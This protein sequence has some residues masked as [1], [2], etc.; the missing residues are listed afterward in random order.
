MADTNRSLRVI[1]INITVTLQQESCQSKQYLWRYKRKKFP[2]AWPGRIQPA[3]Q[4]RENLVRRAGEAGSRA[5]SPPRR[6]PSTQPESH[7]VARRAGEAGCQPASPSTRP[8][9]PLV[10]RRAGEA[11]CQPASPSVP[12]ESPLVARRA[13]E[14]GCQP[15]SPRRPSYAPDFLEVARPARFSRAT[16]PG[17]LTA[18]N[19]PTRAH[20]DTRFVL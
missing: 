2:G 19:F 10:A 5:A 9:S 17:T 13:G 7:L 15:A 1:L 3:A 20:I 4:P 16:R 8:E 12:P 14:A 6:H 18:N 11:G